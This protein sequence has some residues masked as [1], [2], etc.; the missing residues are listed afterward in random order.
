MTFPEGFTPEELAK[1]EINGRVVILEPTHLLFNEQTVHKWQQESQTWYNFYSQV[2]FEAERW[3][4]DLE[5]THDALFDENYLNC[6]SNGCTEKQAEAASRI[7]ANV[8]A[9][10]KKVDDAKIVLGKIKSFIRSFDKAFDTA[11]SMEYRLGREMD[12]VMRT[13]GDRFPGLDAQ[14]EDIIKGSSPENLDP[15]A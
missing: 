14:I 4:T 1:V 5:D 7:D 3:L 2:Q 13:T 11:K 15:L 9:A 8:R 6:K 12:K 10:K